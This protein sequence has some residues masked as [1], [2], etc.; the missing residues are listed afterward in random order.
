M[1]FESS[2]DG[3]GDLASPTTL[4]DEED[5][6]EKKTTM[7]GGANNFHVVGDRKHR[8]KVIKYQGVG[9]GTRDWWVG[10]KTFIIIK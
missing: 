9:W 5:D 4:S 2:Y 3:G 7:A 1:D 6:V 10:P 8:I